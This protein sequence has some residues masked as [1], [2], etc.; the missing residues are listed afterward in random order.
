[1]QEEGWT[2]ISQIPPIKYTYQSGGNASLPTAERQM[3]QNV[4]GIDVKPDPVSLAQLLNSMSTAINN[5]QGI[6]MWTLGW[7]ADYPDPQDFL[8]LQADKG[9]AY[10]SMNYGQNNS[11]DAAQ[12]QATQKLMEQADINPN[13][14]ARMQQYNQVEQQLVDDVAWLPITQGIANVMTKPCVQGYIAN[15]STVPPQDWGNIYIS[16]DT[17]CA[18]A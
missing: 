3:W 14:Q 7:G 8:S 6:Q 17:P 18:S 9:A 13:Q 2:S 15:A 11:A 12:Q 1:M 16:T 10:N 5:P 4:L